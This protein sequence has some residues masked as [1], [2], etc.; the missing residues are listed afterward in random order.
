MVIDVFGD[1]TGLQIYP[2]YLVIYYLEY[3]VIYTVSK[4]KQVNLG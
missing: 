4:T 3:S 2:E 1:V